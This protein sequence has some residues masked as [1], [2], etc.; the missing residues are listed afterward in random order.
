MCNNVDFIERFKSDKKIQYG[1]EAVG[2][3]PVLSHTE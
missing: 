3:E 2:L 1:S